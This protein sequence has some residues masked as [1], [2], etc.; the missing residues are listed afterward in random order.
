MKKDLR[1]T[2]VQNAKKGIYFLSKKYSP[3]EGHH[4]NT[5]KQLTKY[6]MTELQ[7]NNNGQAISKKKK[8][9]SNGDQIF[10]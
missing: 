2:S 5:E 1:S 8:Y 4:I 3:L 6:S 10:N 9:R 7:I